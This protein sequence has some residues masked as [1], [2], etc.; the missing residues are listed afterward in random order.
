GDYDVDGTTSVA[1]VYS[2]FSKI[3][4]NLITYIPDRYSEGYGISIQGIDFA[5]QHQVSLIIVL[6]CGIK[7]HEK[8]NYAK[9]LGIDFIICDH[10]LPAETIPDAVAVLDPK[11]PD[12][13]YPYKEL[14]GCG[15]GFKLIQAYAEKNNINKEQI[16]E[17]LDLVATSIASDLVHVTGENRILAK[18]GVDLVN[19]K[20]RPGIQALINELKLNRKLEITDLVFIIG[21]RI[22]AAG[23][24]AHGSEAVELLVAKDLETA[25]TK[26]KK[27]QENNDTRK[28]F[29]KDT[30]EE[31]F[32]LIEQSELLIQKKSTVLFRPHW[33]KGVIGIVASRLIDKYHRPTIILTESNGKGVGSGRSVPGFDLYEAIDQCSEHLIQFGGHKYAA[34]LTI[35]L[36]KIDV[37]TEMFESVVQHNITEELLIAPIDIDAEIEFSDITDKFYNIIEQM[38]PFGPENMRPTF[39][40]KD[41]YDTG[42]SKVVK[43]AHLKINLLK[44]GQNPVNGIGF[45]MADLYKIM[46]NKDTFDVCY[47]LYAN[48]W[49]NQI[50][51]ELRLK[52]IE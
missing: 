45:G 48:E 2:F 24:I 14:S 5:K 23:R 9:S 27:V 47:Q 25:I 29:D 50:K 10:H 44:D 41:V 11:R 49:N 3:Y 31:A 38:A 51:I 22:N 21:P 46:E 43:E 6:D 8:I 7:A 4:P 12:C 18:F 15:I 34:G 42:F 26:I 40:T 28:E 37:F 52:D 19:K 36:D 39:V 30:T 1:L 32:T 33:H 35:E 13:N 17:E 20:P 16:Y